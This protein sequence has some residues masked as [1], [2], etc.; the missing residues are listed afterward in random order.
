MTERISL[1]GDPLTEEAFAQAY[2]DIAAY[3]DL[4]DADQPHPLSFFETVVGMAFSAFADSPVDVALVEVG[5]GGSWDATN[6]ADGTVAVVTPIAVDHA[7]YLGDHAGTIAGEKA[8]IIKPGAT[9]VVAPQDEDVM[10]VLAERAQEVG[11]TLLREGTEF[12]VVHRAAAVGG[13]VVTC[14]AC[15]G[16]TTRC[17]CRSTAPTRRRTRCSR[18]PRWRCSPAATRWPTTSSARRSAG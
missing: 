6:V 14:R 3:L 8:G 2:T 5:M 15:G 9:V 10:A 11:A 13:Q 7:R 16:A 12:G 4:V 18:W 17:S 1:D